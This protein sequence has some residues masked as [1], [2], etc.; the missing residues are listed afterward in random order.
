MPSKPSK[1]AISFYQFLQ[2]VKQSL[3]LS[4]KRIQESVFYIYRTDTNQVLAR[5][6]DG[7]EAA[8][9]KANRLRRQ[10]GLKWDQVKF[11][12]MRSSFS[13]TKGSGSRAGYKIDSSAL[14]NPSKKTHF[15][16]YY[17]NQG[18]FYDLD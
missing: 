10:L 16:G 2:K 4:E 18:N 11:K 14:Y 8:K 6:I 3:P 9:D 1:K 15:R 12:M 17:D 7:F 13:S 5:G